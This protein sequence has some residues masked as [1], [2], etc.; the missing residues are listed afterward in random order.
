MKYLFPAALTFLILGFGAFFP[1]H[2][3]VGL[4]KVVDGD[5]IDTENDTVRFLG[6][7]TPEVSEF[8]GNDPGDYGL[9]ND[10]DTVDCLDRFGEEASN[11]V[12]NNTRDEVRL[13]FD[14]RSDDRGEY[15]RRLAYIQTEGDL[16]RKLLV[17]GL[18]RVY[19]SG[20]SRSNEFY[21]WEAVAK[22][23][24]RGLWSCD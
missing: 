17:E 5:T 16:T 22:K 4:E 2:E 19:P 20:F 3:M 21:F 11:V 10:S 8:S 13:V 24:G 15:D 14:R 18:A 9:K 6:V 23:N 1:G 12:D 7:D